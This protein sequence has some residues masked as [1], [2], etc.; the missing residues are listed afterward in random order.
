LL[1][2]LS[3]RAGCECVGLSIESAGCGVHVEFDFAQQLHD[4]FGMIAILEE[5]VFEGFRAANE[6]P[7]IKAALFLGDPVAPA[8]L[9]DKGDGRCRIARWRFDKFHCWIP[10]CAEQD[11]LRSRTVPSVVACQRW[12]QGMVAVTENSGLLRALNMLCTGYEFEIG[13]QTIS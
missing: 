3:G 10:C 1:L 9:A 13:A 2:S 7:A 11:P 8:V 4:G 12:I 6:Q 5:G